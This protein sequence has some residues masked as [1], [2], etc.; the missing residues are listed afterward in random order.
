MTF[1]GR[2]SRFGAIA[3]LVVS[4]LMTQLVGAAPT[5]AADARATI[6]SVQ[7]I[8]PGGI[9]EQ[10]AV[11]IGGIKQWITVRGSGADNPILL[12]LHGGPG[13]PMMAESWT[14]QRPWEDYFTVVQWDQR[15]AGKTF[16]AS[17]RKPNQALTIDLMANDTIELI[18]YLRQTYGKKKIFLMGHS[19]GT[20]LGL[21]VARRRPDLL[22]AY[23]GVGQVINMVRNEE[24][25]Y[26]LTLAEAKRQQNAKAIKQL[27]SLFPYP[28]PNGGIPLQKTAILRQWA[29]AM[30]GMMYSQ[31][32]EDDELRR[33]L[34]HYYSA[35]DV[36]SA[37][38]GEM[39]SVLALWPELSKVDFSALHQLHCPLIIFAG[40]YDT[41]TP[42]RL[43]KEFFDQVQAPY[44]HYF[45]MPKAAH[46]VVN[47]SPG[48]TLVALVSHVLPLARGD[49]AFAPTG[50]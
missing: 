7:A 8:P 46:Y 26:Q 21:E 13:T 4:T 31:T 19:W 1:L 41:V 10:K 11:D 24:L 44:K 16:S 28:D 9:S 30:R 27:E 39:Y 43:S 48:L 2:P 22:F 5:S 14:F 6:A 40:E 36:E 45:L 20:V 12:F 3:V 32:G 47:E 18:D 17:R 23:V 15:G 25:G 34:S 35:Y 50:Q 42:G 29:V 49:S 37:G 33:K 38:K